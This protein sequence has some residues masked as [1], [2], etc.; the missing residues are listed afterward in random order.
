MKKVGDWWVPDHMHS[1]GNHIRRSEVIPRALAHLPATRRRFAVQAGGHLGIWP[2]TLAT[3]FEY[4]FTW[5]PMLENLA[6]LVRNITP[7]NNIT[8]TQGCLGDRN[9]FVDME[10]CARNTGKHCVAR[11]SKQAHSSARMEKL[12]DYVQLRVLDALFLDVEGYEYNVL[13]GAEKLIADCLPLI[14]LEQNGLDKRYGHSDKDIKRFLDRHNYV[15]TETFEEDVIYTQ[16]S[17]K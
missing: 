12:D 3:C 1:P 15:K 8:A 2:R 14:V 6:C 10:Y 7:F 16:E 17:W 13:L 5:E 11:L 4:V 9:G